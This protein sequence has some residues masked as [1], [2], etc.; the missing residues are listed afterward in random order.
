MGMAAKFASID[1]YIDAFPQDV[2]TVMRELRQAIKEAAPEAKETI[3]YDMPAFV[4]G[5]AR[6]YFGAW[7]RHIG[8]YGLPAQT[9]EAFREELEPYLNEK[10]S[11]R[12]PLS[13]P[14]PLG[15]IKELVRSQVSVQS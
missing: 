3:S 14:L 2:Q 6:V 8:M 7:K 5:R 11:L 13:K 4:Q 12:F 10:G 1:D 9:I 15:L